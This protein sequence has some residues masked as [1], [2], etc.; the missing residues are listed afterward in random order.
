M[1]V[2]SAAFVP[3]MQ[4]TVL[5]GDWR[6]RQ[7]PMCSGKDDPRPLMAK[8]SS[9]VF[10]L[11]LTLGNQCLFE[12]TLFKIEWLGFCGTSFVR[13][14]FSSNTCIHASASA[15]QGTQVFFSLKK[16]IIK[17]QHSC[18]EREVMVVFLF[19]KEKKKENEKKNEKGCWQW[20][21]TEKC[22]IN[23]VRKHLALVRNLVGSQ[24]QGN[25]SGTRLHYS[26]EI[27]MGPNSPCL[28]SIRPSH[29]LIFQ[30]PI[31]SCPSFV[32]LLLWM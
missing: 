7:E 6:G 3:G 23:Y 1:Q 9:F 21:G 14:C 27:F 12:T 24:L 5:A 4:G 22:L 16:K 29:V 19:T 15:G 30:Q 31:W 18:F 10:M 2:N 11:L 25:P 13:F 8:Q 32:S 28:V 26:S 17:K 20:K